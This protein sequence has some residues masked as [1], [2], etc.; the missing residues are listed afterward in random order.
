MEAT[1]ILAEQ[2][3]ILIKTSVPAN[4]PKINGDREKTT[5]VISNLL[6]NAVRY[7]YENTIVEIAAEA[8]DEFLEIKVKDN[9]MGISP[10]YKNKIFDKYFRIPGAE[11]EGTGL[12]LAI[13][14]EFMEAQGGEISVESELGLGSEFRIL[15]QY[16]Y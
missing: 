16:A 3:N 14:K 4:L 5:W 10:Q 1:K 6:S 11:K 2:K 13:S 7:S 12:G 8:K 15:L 9:G